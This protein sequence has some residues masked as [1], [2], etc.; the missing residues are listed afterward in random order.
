MSV[1]VGNLVFVGFN[2]RVA[3][4]DV[5]SGNTVWSWRAPDGTGYVSLLLLDKQR[6]I[7][8]VVGYTYCLDPATG[9]QLWYNPLSGF[10]TGVTSLT[11]LGVGNSRDPVMA[12]AESNAT[13][14]STGTSGI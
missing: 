7:A 5:E 9:R 12:A 10:G 4:L 11:A 2:S 6:L 8:S 1:N 14:Q 3:A 13:R